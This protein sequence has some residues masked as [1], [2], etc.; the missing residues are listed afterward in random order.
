MNGGKMRVLACFAAAFM[1]VFVAGAC[2]T[3][4]RKLKPQNLRQIFRLLKP[5]AEPKSNK[6]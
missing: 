4:L 5:Q 6:T 3:A 1:A 2:S